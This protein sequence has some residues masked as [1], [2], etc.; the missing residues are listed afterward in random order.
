MKSFQRPILTKP[1]EENSN[2]Y[3]IHRWIVFG[4]ISSSYLWVYFHRVS[5][6][7]I[8]PDLL[9]SFQTHAT[10]LGFISSMFF[11]LYALEQPF[12]G[13][14]SDKL[15]P[16][17]VVGFWS[18]ATAL[19]CVLFGIAPTMAWAAVG[20]ALIGLGSGGVY[21]PALKAFSQ[22]FRKKEFATMT[23]LFLSIGNL[24]AIM[25]TTPLAWMANVCGWRLSFLI[26]GSITFG[27]AVITL[28]SIKDHKRTG[29]TI[30][31]EVLRK[32]PFNISQKTTNLALSSFGFW[33]LAALF[34]GPFGVYFTFQGLWATPFLM[35]VLHVNQISA[36]QL[37]ML[38]PVGYLLGAPLS[39][40]LADRA[41]R[42]KVNVIIFLLSIK[43]VIWL[44]LVIRIQSLSIGSTIAIFLSLGGITGGLS[45]ILWALVRVYSS[46]RTLGFTMG[47][48]NA[49]PL[50]G[51]AIFQGWTGRILD[52]SESAVVIYSPEA[53]KNVLIICL[54]T[55]AVC[56]TICGFL[57][58]YIYEKD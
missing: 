6:S 12:I 52:S 43:A 39:G 4:A 50:L 25:A 37:N 48:L 49:F 53:Y 19:G 28:L 29:N 24:G 23:G 36:S 54:L 42:S 57:K 15:G 38:L 3:G 27:L 9:A 47:L 7:V 40:W 1:N 41:F 17:R 13:Y 58:I 21:I 34:F 8:A 20:R 2:N 35:S 11:Y 10:A 26:I 5:T 18:L 14:L 55:T 31:T 45:T 56:L 33:I 30:Q 51:I 46:E 22:W 32:H 16:R 44:I